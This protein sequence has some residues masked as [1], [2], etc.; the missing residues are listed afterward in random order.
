VTLVLPPAMPP[1]TIEPRPPE[2]ARSSNVAGWLALN[3]ESSP[4]TRRT[5]TC[6]PVT[7]E[8]TS[9]V[10]PLSATSSAAPL[11]SIG[12]SDGGISIVLPPLSLPVAQLVP[13]GV[14]CVFD[15]TIASRSV[16]RP[17]TCASPPTST[18]ACG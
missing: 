10:P 3:T 6:V 7:V 11:S 4:D 14:A 8:R 9:V 16:Q 15:A 1:P 2:I 5:A 17:E 13:A 12:D 18:A